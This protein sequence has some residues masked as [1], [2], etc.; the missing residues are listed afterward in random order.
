[1]TLFIISCYRRYHWMSFPL[2]AVC[3]DIERSHQNQ[4][5]H[6]WARIPDS[7]AGHTGYT[8]WNWMV[9]HWLESRSS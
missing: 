6:L 3:C 1:M 7:C 8:L 2:L 5:R 9:C 4:R